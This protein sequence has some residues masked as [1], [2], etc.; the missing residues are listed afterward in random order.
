[1]HKSSKCMT[2]LPVEMEC[3]KEYEN[4]KFLAK[5][6]VEFKFSD[7]YKKRLDRLQQNYDNPSSDEKI[8]KFIKYFIKQWLNG[9]VSPT[10]WN[11]HQTDKRR[12]NNDVERFH[13]GLSRSNITVHPR[14]DET[15]KQIKLIDSKARDVFYKSK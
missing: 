4:L 15:K 14:V 2:M 9:S 6:N 1:M 3:L 12:T 8:I 13:S 5:T 11:H 7:Q 10:I